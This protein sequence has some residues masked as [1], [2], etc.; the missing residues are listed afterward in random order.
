MNNSMVLCKGRGVCTKNVGGKLQR[1]HCVLL[2]LEK[3][4]DR[5]TREEL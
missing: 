1:G 2:D 3:V 4:Y 5:V